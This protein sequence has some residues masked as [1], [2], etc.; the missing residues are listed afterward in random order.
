MVEKCRELKPLTGVQENAGENCWVLC[1]A[2][3]G[4]IRYISIQG[5]VWPKVGWVAR[6]IFWTT[7]N[8][9]KAEKVIKVYD[10]TTP[11]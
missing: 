8:M 3:R 2:G 5:P 6:G 4:R 7:V 11:D 10:G 9:E 1:F